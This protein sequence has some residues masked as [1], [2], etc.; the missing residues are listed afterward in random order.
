[1]SI[2]NLPFRRME[3]FLLSP[4]VPKPYIHMSC[5]S[6]DL[7]HCYFLIVKTRLSINPL[8]NLL[9]RNAWTPE[10]KCIYKRILPFT[11]FECPPHKLTNKEATL[12]SYKRLFPLQSLSPTLRLHTTLP[13]RVSNATLLSYAT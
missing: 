7:H 2:F 9:S 1:M 12:N 3:H 4:I 10:I 5:R 13:F 8:M 6:E 11:H